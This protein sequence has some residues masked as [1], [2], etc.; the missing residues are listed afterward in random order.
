MNGK[1]F[2]HSRMHD[3]FYGPSNPHCPASGHNIGGDRQALEAELAGE[4]DVAL[5]MYK[6]LLKRYDN[7]YEKD[8]ESQES[9]RDTEENEEEKGGVGE[10]GKGWAT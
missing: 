7:R 5:G 3:P 6:K 10:G 4:Y 1:R 2:I 9:M 8:G